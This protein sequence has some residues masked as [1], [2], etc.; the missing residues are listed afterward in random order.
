[1]TKEKFDFSTE[2]KEFDAIKFKRVLKDNLWKRSKAKNSKEYLA[3]V[4]KVGKNSH[5]NK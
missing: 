2:E 5:V 1:M 4:K 3:Y